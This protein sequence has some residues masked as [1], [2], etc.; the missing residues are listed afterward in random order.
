MLLTAL[1]GILYQD[2]QNPQEE[3]LVTTSVPL[4]A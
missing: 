2:V 1:L 3:G 4:E